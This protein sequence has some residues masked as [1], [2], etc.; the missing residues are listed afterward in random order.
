MSDF[1]DVFAGAAS[2]LF[3]RFADPVT[4]DDQ[5]GYRAVIDQET[6]ALEGEATFSTHE[7]RTAEFLLAELEPVRGRPLVHNGN[8]Y[9]IGQV[10]ERT[11][12]TVKHMLT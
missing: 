4:Y 11:A 2:D 5:A 1:D 10:I 7:Q 12:T 3:D 8:R 9:T 6:I